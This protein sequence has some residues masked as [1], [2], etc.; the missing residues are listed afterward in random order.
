MRKRETSKGITLVVSFLMGRRTVNSKLELNDLE[1][2]WIHPLLASSLAAPLDTVLPKLWHDSVAMFH[3]G[4]SGSTVLGELLA[5]SPEMI[6]DREIYH[7]ALKFL[8][9]KKKGYRSVDN[10][11]FDPIKLVRNRMLL[12]RFIHPGKRIYGCEIKFYH[13]RRMGI[14]LED[15]INYLESIGFK[16]F[17]ILERKNYLRAIV[18]S[19]ISNRKLKNF[20]ISSGENPQLIQIELDTELLKTD[21]ECKSL[22]EYLQTHRNDF[23]RL[24]SILSD[25][26][27]L[28]LTYEE[29]IASDPRVGARR[30]YD[31]LDLGD[32]R[33]QVR[34]GKTNPYPLCEIITNFDEVERVLSG[35]AFEWMV[36]D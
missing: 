22:L 32:R 23:Q 17:I 8:R 18:S 24:E 14:D 30:V 6:W 29:D 33:G 1:F 25:R 28:K 15:Y 13:L 9:G 21:G 12:R 4:R 3:I 26:Y 19:I 27:T 2:S 36:Y 20:H 5:R 31:F 10:L 16:S 35:T 34:Y 11:S 7:L